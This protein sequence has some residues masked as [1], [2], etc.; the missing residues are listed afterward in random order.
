MFITIID[1]EGKW[2]IID[3]ICIPIMRA[4]FIFVPQYLQNPY[5]QTPGLEEEDEAHEDDTMGVADTYADY[6]PAKCTKISKYT[7]A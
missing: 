3:I 1:Y 2:F 6:K 7:H 4:W 5:N